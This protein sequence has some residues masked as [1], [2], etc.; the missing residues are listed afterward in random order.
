MR[1]PLPITGG[2]ASLEVHIFDGAS[3]PPAAFVRG[4]G[5]FRGHAFDQRSYWRLGYSPSQHHF[6]R[7]FGVLFDA[8]VD[9]VRG[10]VIDRVA[11]YGSVMQAAA[12]AVDCALVPLDNLELL[13]GRVVR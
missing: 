11:D 10:I 3:T 1:W 7:G 12:R 9:G 6:Y 13:D 5:T 2:Q 8:P 4:S